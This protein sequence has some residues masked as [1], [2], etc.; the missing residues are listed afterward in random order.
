MIV[1]GSKA[2]HLKTVELEEAIC[3]SCGTEDSL[4]LS[5]YRKHIHLFWIPIIAI[6][7]RGQSVCEYCK[8]VMQVAYMPDEVKRDYEV[9]KKEN[10]GPVWQHIGLVLI[11]GII[12]SA[13]IMSSNNKKLEQEYLT[14]PLVG[15]VYSYKIG[16]KQYSTFKVVSVSND[17]V[18]VS[19]N[20]YETNKTTGIR[21]VDN[22]EN[23]AD[24]IIG[25]AKTRISSMYDEGDIFNVDRK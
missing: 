9:L 16:P 22:E 24:M 6:G 13:N 20:E 4:L 14:A 7:K 1:F 15:D 21:D 10:K 23:Y 5:V 25:M 19:P 17:T 12:I 8:H 3:P 2:V 11:I 18:F